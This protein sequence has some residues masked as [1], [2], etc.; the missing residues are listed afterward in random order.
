MIIRILLL[1]LI[2]CLIGCQSNST[3]QMRPLD[4]EKINH[5]LLS[6]QKQDFSVNYGL[7]SLL[8]ESNYIILSSDN[9]SINLAQDR[10]NNSH[11][12]LIENYAAPGDDSIKSYKYLLTFKRNKEGLWVVTEA[13][14]SWSC[15]PE[16]GHQDFSTKSCL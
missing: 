8:E 11:T 9:V 5:T 16:R 15:W 13:R 10:K 4:L 1:I 2:S 6:K 3:E 12:A 14:E 7:M